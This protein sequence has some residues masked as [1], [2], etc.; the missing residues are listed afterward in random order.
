MSCE[1]ARTEELPGS[2]AFV[3]NVSRLVDA[4]SFTR[5]G[6]QRAVLHNLRS[7]L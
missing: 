2:Y 7:D 4:P 3:V 6:A 1:G 5:Y